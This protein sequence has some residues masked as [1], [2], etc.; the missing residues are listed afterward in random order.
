MQDQIK[1]LKQLCPDIMACNEGE[2]TYYLL[3]NL[4]L[5]QG[6]SPSTVDALLCPAERDGYPSRLFFATQITSKSS[7]NWNSQNVRILDR[8]W[9][10][11]SWK[12]NIAG[13]RLAEL[14]ANHLRA[15][16]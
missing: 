4:S 8:N 16:Q 15:L 5:P 14:V 6:C 1:E 3:R 7:R 2:I 12:L 10:A 11:F 13:Q 9:F